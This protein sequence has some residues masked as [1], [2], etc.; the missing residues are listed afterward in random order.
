[1]KF[2]FLIELSNA[3]VPL[4]LR[5]AHVEEDCFVPLD[6]D[7]D[8]QLVKVDKA[9]IL[10]AQG[11]T[12]LTRHMAW[13]QSKQALVANDSTE[14]MFMSE[15]FNEG[16]MG[17]EPTEMARTIAASLQDGLREF[18]GVESTVSY[19]GKSLGKL[20]TVL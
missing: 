4:E 3:N 2:V 20:D 7:T 17:T 1:M 15:V 13:R 12:V 14:I 19:L 9:E 11:N 18:F 5:L 8:A 16:A 10:Y 6:A